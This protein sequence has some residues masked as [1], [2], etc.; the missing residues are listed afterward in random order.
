MSTT[1]SEALC[2]VVLE[3]K[4]AGIEAAARD[5]RLL[6]AYAVD[7]APERLTL[8]MQDAITPA[9]LRVL[10]DAVRARLERRPMSHILG[11]RN[12]WGRDF[13]VT[14]DV[15]DPRPETE[16][17]IKAALEQPYSK[18][19][20]LGTGAGNILL[21]LLAERE[22]ASG[23]GVDAS[24]EAL[25]IAVENRAALG[26]ERRAIFAESDWF[27][28]VVGQFDLVVAN[29]P[30]I[31]LPE[32]GALAPEVQR[33]E[34][35]MALTPGISG[36]EAYQ[37]IAADITGFL[38]PAARVLLEVGPEQAEEVAGL[39][40]NAGLAFETIHNDMDGRARVVEMRQKR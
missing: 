14:S 10:D 18:V 15:L 26:L 35:M 11:R 9:G 23:T 36:L 21:T 30:Y 22:N 17:L 29:P 32:M 12:F 4:A 8:V 39:F 1:I 38:T 6:M 40:Q 16:A 37:A 33:W 25:K 31:S 20:D 2:A 5:A 24:P 13:K 27:E 28:R 3:L 34:P 7:V 19:L